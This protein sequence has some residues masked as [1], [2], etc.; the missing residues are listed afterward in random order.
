[1]PARP[2]AAGRLTQVGF[3]QDAS[4]THKSRRFH[5]SRVRTAHKAV[6]TMRR[7]IRK[8]RGRGHPKTH[9]DAASSAASDLLPA[10]KEDLTDG[11][12]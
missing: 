2:T 8:I 4:V 6:V 9:T 5:T 12:S 10:S 3:T 1:M 11:P 7:R